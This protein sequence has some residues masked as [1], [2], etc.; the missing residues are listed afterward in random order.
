[1]S[2]ATTAGTRLFAVLG[3]PVAHSLSPRLHSAAIAARDL[4]AV[5]LALR[6]GPHDAPGLIRAIARAGGGG[7]VTVPHKE[8]AAEAVERT[9]AAVE[10]T[11]ACN[12]FWFHEG[13]VWGDNTDV[14][15][16]RGAVASLRPAGVAGARAL[17]LGAGGAARAALFA[18]IDGGAAEVAV[19]NR[20][21]A[22]ARTLTDT[23][24]EGRALALASAS[25][26]DGEPFDLVVNATSLGLHPADALPLDVE[27]CGEVGAVLDLVYGAQPTPLV[28]SARRCGIPADDGRE[29]LLLQAAAAFRNWFGDPVPLDAMRA[30][31]LP[32]G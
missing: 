23:V 19:L 11:G 18:L 3:D 30:T 25:D 28:R 4:D 7:N 6:C 22:R 27:R 20:T 29:M 15:G 14:A 10:R 12:T 17:L 31:M 2:R 9:T 21:P 16:F 26:V 32:P 13:E 24:G 5:Y 8:R 1:M